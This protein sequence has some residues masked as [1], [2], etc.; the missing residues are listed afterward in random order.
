M[1]TLMIEHPIV[2]FDTWKAAFDRDPA[3]RKKSGVRR[4]RVFRPAD[5]AKYVIIHLDF[6]GATEA[7]AFLESMRKVWSRVELS[8][9]LSREDGAF[10]TS[11]RARI[12]E[13]VDSKDFEPVRTSS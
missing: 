10:K 8:L 3:E 12:V 5:D 2:D 9:G 7:Q 13:E 6:D 4:Y 1:S 11:P